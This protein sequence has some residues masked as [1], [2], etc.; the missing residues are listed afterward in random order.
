MA[1]IPTCVQIQ[2]AQKTL[3]AT[4]EYQISKDSA[5]LWDSIPDD[6]WEHL[7]ASGPLDLAAERQVLRIFS[8][9]AAVQEQ[10]QLVN[11]EF[12]K[13]FTDGFCGF[14]K[15]AAVSELWQ[16]KIATR[17]LVFNHDFIALGNNCR[18]QES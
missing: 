5:E 15:Y 7:R 4:T 17:K 18:K 16:A 11:T 8:F 1:L 10:K 2:Q 12:W 9:V 6:V 13:E 3:T 14:L